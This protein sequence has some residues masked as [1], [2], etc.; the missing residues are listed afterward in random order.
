MFQTLILLHNPGAEMKNRRVVALAIA[1]L[2]P[3]SG[4][5]VGVDTA[6][7]AQATYSGT[8]GPLLY[9][10]Y[11]PQT[12]MTTV[13][14]STLA[15]TA[16]T[17]AFTG[18]GLPI[19]SADGTKAVWMESAGQSWSIKMSNTNGT[20]TVTVVSGS[21]SPMPNNPSFSPDGTKIILSYDRDIHIIDAAASQTISSSNRILD[22][23]GM[24][25]ASSPQYITATTIAY[26]GE[27]PSHSCG[28]GYSG[29][30]VKDLTNSSVGTLLT[31][32][33]VGGMNREY[34]VAFDVSPNGQF[35]IFRY[36]AAFG[37]VAITKT[38][39]TGSKINVVLGSSYS[40]EPSG[41]PVFSPDG[42]N[43]LYYSSSKLRLA[44]FN[45]TAVGTASEVPFPAGVFAP[46]TL[47]WASVEANIGA[48]ASPSPSPSPTTAPVS[49]GSQSV[50]SPNVVPGVTITDTNVYTTAAPREV[51][52]GSAIAVLTPAQAKTQRIQSLT[53]SVCVPTEDDIVFLDEG[54]CNASVL[55]KRTGEVLRRIRTTVIE[56]DVV[57]LGVGNEIVTLAPIYFQNGSSILS[58]R[59]R[60]RVASLKDQISA[61]GTVMV[62]GHTGTMLGDTPENQALSRTRA[63]NTVRE[64]RRIRASG[65]FYSLGVG[66]LDP[67]VPSTER[68]KQAQNRR[69]VIVLIP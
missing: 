7:Q 20:N 37:A 13:R 53:P 34:S 36:I 25:I 63:I 12:M 28:S 65:P 33:C 68:S 54:R 6:R 27:Q 26:L 41:R 69:V 51:A 61:A 29:I 35:V 16:V 52:S 23:S 57:N 11:S 19:L 46:S 10:S 67:A 14:A 39:N 56:D 43:I 66:A 49:S 18:T 1:V 64:M 47:T 60:D 44:S 31:N 24:N 8:N 42:A 48:A 15:G 59:A 21:G 5:F 17:T 58:K 50:A 22:S 38:D 55:S 62:I 4:V 9:T 30:Y 45:G 32:T 3:L 2:T 40:N